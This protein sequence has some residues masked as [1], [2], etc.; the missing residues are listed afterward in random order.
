MRWF[1][2]LQF[3]VGSFVLLFAAIFPHP[4]MAA[5]VP[6]SSYEIVVIS[7]RAFGNLI[8]NGDHQQAIRRIRGR[9][10]LYPFSAAN[11]LCAANT[12]LG[13]FGDALNFCDRA[14]EVAERASIPRQKRWKER[15][16]MATIAALA[17]SNRGVLRVLMGDE[18]G[19]EDDFQAAI[20]LKEDM[21]AP[22]HNFARLHMDSTEPV[23]VIISNH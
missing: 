5:E 9:A 6:H 1:N 8:M 13:R 4:T 12:A 17:Y 23:A 15:A 14:I 7:N 21:R 19:A 16:H 10:P 20:E 3:R 2:N 11:N 22:L 18:A